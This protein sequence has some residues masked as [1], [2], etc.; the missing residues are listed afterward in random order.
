MVKGT[1]DFLGINHYTTYFTYQSQKATTFLMD[2][3]VDHSPDENY[4]AS[5][6][7]WLQ[8]VPWGFRKL[9]DWIAKEYKNLPVL[10]IENGFADKGELNDRES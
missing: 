6:A 7:K 8:V 5:S 4:A 3:G 9:L 10:V 1:W 2:T